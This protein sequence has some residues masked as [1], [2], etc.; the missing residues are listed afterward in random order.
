MQSLCVNLLGYLNCT[1]WTTQTAKSNTLNEAGSL[2]FQHDETHLIFP[3][4]N[5]ES[6]MYLSLEVMS[7]DEDP[8]PDTTR[9]SVPR[10]GQRLRRRRTVFSSMQLHFLEQKF[11][12]NH[13]LTIPERDT[14]AMSL[15]L[16]SRQVKTWF[17]NRRTKWRD[18]MGELVQP[19][20]M[21][22][23]MT[24]PQPMSTYITPPPP[25]PYRFPM[26]VVPHTLFSPAINLVNSR[27][28]STC[29]RWKAPLS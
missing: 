28:M 4:S 10:R 1:Q 20:S 17:Q 26:V 19:T 5:H 22:M 11:L 15:N 8:T 14:L 7:E 2:L 9:N 13:Y 16:N 3:Q 6:S 23:N 29:Y 25:H 21:A 27:L 12:S 24:L 18:G